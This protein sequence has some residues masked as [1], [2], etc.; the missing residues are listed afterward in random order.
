MLPEE[1]SPTWPAELIEL[2][3][4]A[5]VHR[6][7]FILKLVFPQSAAGDEGNGMAVDA[8]NRCIASFRDLLDHARLPPALN[9][10]V[11]TTIQRF[12]VVQGPLSPDLVDRLWQ[13]TER[14]LLRDLAAP[15]ATLEDYRTRIGAL[16]DRRWIGEHA[17]AIPPGWLAIVERAVR[18]AEAAAT[19]E[20]LDSAGTVILEERFA[21]LEWVVGG[22]VAK[23]GAVTLYAATASRFVCMVCGAPGAPDEGPQKGR[24]LTLCAPHRRL[25]RDDADAFRL[26]LYPGRK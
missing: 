23:I 15:P 19:A 2:A 14:C 11:R 9:D 16:E 20:E 13:E 1:I 4:M 22:H 26:A 25:R 5:E 18:V 8:A 24:I 21:R 17:R 6:L 3:I 10:A 7:G 12:A